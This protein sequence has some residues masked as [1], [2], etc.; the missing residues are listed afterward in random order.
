M[1][2][3]MGNAEAV[4]LNHV[5]EE[6]KAQKDYDIIVLGLQ[7]ST[8]SKGTTGTECIAHLGGMIQE[9]VGAEFFKVSEIIK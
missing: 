6:R 8:Y 2:W 7:E 5:L 4:G 1:S 9:I 3:N